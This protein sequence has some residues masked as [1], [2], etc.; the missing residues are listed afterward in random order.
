MAKPKKKKRK[1]R[2]VV[3]RYRKNDPDH[4]IIVATQR[5]I[6]AHG[7]TAIVIGGVGI[8]DEEN[9]FVLGTKFKYQV[10]IGAMGQKPM[11]EKTDVK[12]P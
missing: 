9:P 12:T 10:C 4:N 8:L 7:G 3:L 6:H 1:Q 11:K 2:W 5:W